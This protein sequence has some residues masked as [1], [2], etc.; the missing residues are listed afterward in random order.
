MAF[1][2]F[3]HE[4]VES[5][6][7]PVVAYGTALFPSTSL[8]NHACYSTCASVS[9]G[10]MQVMRACRFIPA[11]TQITRQY[12]NLYQRSLEDRASI[13]QS[14]YHFIC[15]C[16]AC[17]GN[18]PRS[19]PKNIND[20]LRCVVCQKTVPEDT[21]KCTEC[22][23]TYDH[24]GPVE[25]RPEVTAYNYTLVKERLDIALREYMLRVPRFM[26]GTDTEEDVK[27][28]EELLHMYDTY[29]VLPTHGHIAT[30]SLLHSVRLREGNSAFVRGE[31]WQDCIVS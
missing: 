8:L 29:V 1:F 31:N 13:L 27:A 10:L 3:Q 23:V 12:A 17:E 18:W 5:T 9:Y 6:A 14:R 4:E 25:G 26:D 15:N 22:T 11:G 21:K 20:E 24:Y 2:F 28:I 19:L 7:S 16:K 30:Q